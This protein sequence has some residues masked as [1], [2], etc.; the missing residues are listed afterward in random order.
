VPVLLAG[1]AF[2]GS[3]WSVIAFV[4]TYF[5]AKITAKAFFTGSQ[6]FVSALL[7][8][9]HIATLAFFFFIIAFLFNKYNDFLALVASMVGKSEILS[10]VYQILQSLGIFNAFND[11]FAIFSQPLLLYLG[12][13]VIVLV[14]KALENTSNELFKVGVLTQQ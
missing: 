14:F 12:Y 3:V 1:V 2:I 6:I 13:R 9:A 7:I 4:G 8:T 5:V 10:L 11:V